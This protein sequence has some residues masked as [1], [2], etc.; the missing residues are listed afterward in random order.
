MGI[1][2]SI[3]WAVMRKFRFDRRF[4]AWVQVLY[5]APVSA[6]Q[7]EGRISPSFSLHKGTRQG[8]PLS[9]LLFA[10]AIEPMAAFIRSDNLI[11]GLHYGELHEKR[12]M[13]AD[14]TIM[15]LGDTSTSLKGA[16]TVIRK[17]GEYSGLVINWT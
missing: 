7:E 14:D 17:F 1:S 9:P 13:Y 3:E 11:Q 6:I 2:D 4:I 8:C 5:S 10:L 12:M 15:F 16:M